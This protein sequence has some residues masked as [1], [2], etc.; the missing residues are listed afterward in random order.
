MKIIGLTGSIGMGKSCAAQA[1]RS[2]GVAV[3]DAD[4]EIHKLLAAGGGG[5]AD[6]ARA[7]PGV[8]GRDDRDRDYINRARLAALV[9]GDDPALRRLEGILHPLAGRAKARFIALAGRRGE[10]MVVLDIPLLLE[11]GG[12]AD[13]DFV[14]V[15]SAPPFVQR[16]RVLRRPGMT[17]E[18]LQS[19]LARQIPDHEKRRRADFVVR[20]GLGRA[21]SLRA[22]AGF[23]RIVGD[24]S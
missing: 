4:A 19:I 9:F 24:F 21:F 5:V 8:L 2:C 15:V 16:Q 14:V 20:T 17:P 12:D 23:V 1:F 18:R 22:I 3:Y 7:F 6:V 13:C 11:T 10:S